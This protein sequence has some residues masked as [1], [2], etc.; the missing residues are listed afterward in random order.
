MELS[1]DGRQL[2]FEKT[3]AA[4]KALAE[5]TRLRILFL[6]MSGEL[7]VKD[8]TRVLG[9]SQPRISRHLKL[10]DEAELIQ[11]YREGNWVYCR[12]V[13]GVGPAELMATIA[14]SMPADEPVLTRDR[15]RLEAVRRENSETA[16]A[17]FNETAAE[18]DRIRALQVGEGEVETAILKLAGPG[19]FGTMIDLGTGT[20][21]MLEVFADRITHGIG[22]DQ[23]RSMLG[24]A[25]ARAE[26]ARLDHCQIR[27]GDILALPYEDGLADLVVLHQV[28][29]Y[30]DDPQPVLAEAARVLAAGG[31]LVMVD[32]APHDLE[33]LRTDYAHR[34]LGF[35]AGQI[36][37]WVSR[38]GLEL[39]EPVDLVRTGE[40]PE[41]NLTVSVW[42]AT[43]A[44]SD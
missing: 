17:Y 37:D 24:L 22:I 38:L 33:F 30:F 6:L 39:A 1:K 14:A 3:I 21:R 41:G 27:H 44:A 2:G 15:A 13:G 42:L 31:R 26:R 7:N 9:Q 18:W 28:L 32:F 34:R 35:S 5:P 12:L 19:P 10:L 16:L 4:L 11:R 36:S 23:S 20:G 8:L 25:R 29:H 43:Q 40:T